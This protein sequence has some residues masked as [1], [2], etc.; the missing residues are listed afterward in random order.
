MTVLFMFTYMVSYLTRINYG[1]VIAEIEVAE[2]LSKSLLSM[3]VTGSF[4]TYGAGQ[5]ISGICGDRFS[6]KKL[7]SLGL[8][9][10]TVM[11]L[12]I[13]LM[14]DPYLYAGIW[15]INGFAQA[16][17]WPPLVRMLSANLNEEDYKSSTEKVIWGS[18]FGT[19]GVYLLAPVFIGTVGW[20]ALFFFC[21]ASGAVMFF[22]WNRFAS[23]GLAGP[24][25]S[26]KVAAGEKISFKVFLSPL[27][28]CVLMAIMCQGML[29]DGV[30]TWM[31]SNISETYDLSSSISILTGV[32]LPIFSLVFNRAAAVLYKRFFKNPLVCA[33]VIFFV[34]V[35][36]SV[37]LIFFSGRFAAV[38]V[39]F[40]ALLTGCMHGV[41]LILVCMLPAYFKKHGNVSTAAGVLNSFTYVGSAV[42]TYGIA[43][44][45]ESLGWSFTLMTWVLIAAVG[46]ALCFACS[47]KWS[48]EYPESE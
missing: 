44:L 37:V 39:I 13:P 27:I 26:K 30:T 3:A 9:V 34:G 1:A 8:T 29:R 23:D 19:I 20:R 11:N 18:S 24:S 41:N 6:P 31:P 48:A 17:M 46:S 38:S 35:I 5:I 14:K 28:L 4:I 43:L 21:A 33:G 32:L 12:L 7:V 45:S 2:N 25:S 16:F 22:F 10:T 42:S 40:S 36:S 15:C 47:K